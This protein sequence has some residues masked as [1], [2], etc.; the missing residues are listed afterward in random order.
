MG[1]DLHENGWG[2]CRDSCRGAGAAI[3]KTAVIVAAGMGKRLGSRTNGRP[4][5]FLVIDEKP[6]IE[7]SIAKL[8]EVGID[9]IVIG[10]GYVS[11]MYERLAAR[12]PQIQC[13]YND[14]YESTGSMYTLYQLKDHISE[15]FILLESDLIYEKKALRRLM[16]DE[17]PDVIL[18]STFTH[19]GDEVFIETDEDRHLVNLSKRVEDLAS[20]Y[21]EYVGMTKLSCTAFHA[22]CRY[23]AKMLPTTSTLDYE[24]AL[25]GISKEVKLFVRKLHDLAWCEVDNEYHWNQAALQIYPMIKAREA[26][27]SNGGGQGGEVDGH[28]KAEI[29]RCGYGDQ[30][31]K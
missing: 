16:E 7:H 22:M 5:G 10:T 24:H 30:P 18:A 2:G 28:S 19:S 4:K 12:Y 25:I 26:D 29:G 11:E 14:H 13:V 1:N 6:I 3:V 17:R 23:V 31:G 21:A 9:K 15:D 20:I 8:L 27:R